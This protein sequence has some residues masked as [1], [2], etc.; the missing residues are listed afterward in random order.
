MF[1]EEQGVD[2]TNDPKVREVLHAYYAIF[3]TNQGKLVL[4]DMKKKYGRAAP[5]VA[6]GN[7]GTLGWFEGRRSVINDLEVAVAAGERFVGTKSVSEVKTPDV[8]FE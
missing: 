6:I 1:E 4:E 5:V 2:I 7:H 8:E 3:S